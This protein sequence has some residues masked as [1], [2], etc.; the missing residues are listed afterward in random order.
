MTRTLRP[1]LPADLPLLAILMQASFEELA[2]DEYSAAQRAAWTAEAEDATAFG[3]RLAT[4]LTLVVEDD[5]EPAAFA[6]LEGN[7]RVSHVYVHP[8]CSGEGLGRSLLEAL[9]KLAAARGGTGLAALVT[10]NATGFFERLGYVAARRGTHA[11]GEQW[12][13][14]TDMTRMLAAPQGTTVQ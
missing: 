1:L 14:V 13:G 7:S 10:D 8:D 5:G 11:A 3:R 12:L 9:E 6:V 2:A 4:G